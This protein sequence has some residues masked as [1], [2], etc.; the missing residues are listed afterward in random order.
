MQAGKGDQRR[1][2]LVL[3]DAVV[4]MESLP[5]FAPVREEKGRLDARLVRRRRQV[6]VLM[7]FW[8]CL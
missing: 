8:D 7:V 5:R 6:A 4:I 2:V 1:W 3:G